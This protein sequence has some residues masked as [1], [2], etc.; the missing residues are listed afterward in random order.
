MTNYYV[1]E[2]IQRLRESKSDDE[3]LRLALEVMDGMPARA[4]NEDYVK[5]WSKTGLR[6]KTIRANYASM[7]GL[8]PSL[9][10]L[11]SYFDDNIDT[12]EIKYRSAFAIDSKTNKA[13]ISE[14]KGL[15]K[16]SKVNAIGMKTL[17]GV[18]NEIVDYYDSGG[19]EEVEYYVG[20]AD[21][22]I[23]LFRTN[24]L[25]KFDEVVVKMREMSLR[26][27]KANEDFGVS[28]LFDEIYLKEEC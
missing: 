1:Y 9:V 3:A 24:E 2:L 20:L 10:T 6:L 12:S 21:E 11:S 8:R 16:D 5:A 18:R 26:R 15:F 13:L 17:V 14:I 19:V 28:S 22:G 4:Y 7:E 25:V 27:N 23:F